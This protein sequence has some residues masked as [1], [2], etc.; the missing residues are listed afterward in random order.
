MMMRCLTLGFLGLMLAGCASNTAPLVV[1]SPPGTPL[2]PPVGSFATS[3][4]MGTIYRLP[5]RQLEVFLPGRGSFVINGDDVRD[6]VIAPLAKPDASELALVSTMRPG[7]PN[8]QYLILYGAF[9]PDFYRLGDCD[10]ALV[11]VP[12]RDGYT[13]IETR[14]GRLRYRID[15]NRVAVLNPEPFSP[16]KTPPAPTP[17]EVRS[18]PS[19]LPLRE[20]VAPSLTNTGPAPAGMPETAEPMRRR[21]APAEFSIPPVGTLNVE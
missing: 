21:V 20:P 1:F 4:G 6:V 17:A 3:I 8:D 11:I 2:G 5:D 12:Q 15:G 19:P 14:D 10:S 7:C 13:V 16:A 9:E 18:L